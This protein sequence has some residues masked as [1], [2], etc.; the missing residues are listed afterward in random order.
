MSKVFYPQR[1]W[2][3]DWHRLFGLVWERLISLSLSSPLTVSHWSQSC[4]HAKLETQHPPRTHITEASAEE[5][6]MERFLFCLLWGKKNK[7]LHVGRC[8]ILI[9][10]CRFVPDSKC[11]SGHGGLGTSC[12][13]GN[14]TCTA[15]WTGRGINKHWRLLCDASAQPIHHLP[16]PQESYQTR[17]ENQ[18]PVT[19]TKAEGG[20]EKRG[21]HA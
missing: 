16:F 15:P 10:P 5:A 7:N 19:R 9:P 18:G 11:L 14:Q 6:A 13:V 2:G 20:W 12:C 17:R 21:L 1:D 3:V 8:W 4:M